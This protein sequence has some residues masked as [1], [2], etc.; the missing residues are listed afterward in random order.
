MIESQ[1]LKQFVEQYESLDREKAQVAESQKDVL[2]EVKAAGGDKA[3]FRKIIA[4]RKKDPTDIELE[5]VLVEE[6]KQALG[7]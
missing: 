3:A 2:D 6:Y 4:L 7:M 1:V 5:E